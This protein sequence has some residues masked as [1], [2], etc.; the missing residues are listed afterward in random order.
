MF[1][2]YTFIPSMILL[3]STFQMML[4]LL[5]YPHLLILAMRM[6]VW[7]FYQEALMILL[8]ILTAGRLGGEGMTLTLTIMRHPL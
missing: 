3:Y 5:N 8:I 6:L 7:H 4:L 2:Q 1:L